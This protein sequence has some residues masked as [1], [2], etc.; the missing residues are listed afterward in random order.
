M[1]TTT[2]AVTGESPR[3][4]VVR[5]RLVMRTLGS[6]ALVMLATPCAAGVAEADTQRTFEGRWVA[7]NQSLTLDLSRCGQALLGS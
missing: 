5:T 2:T 6:V 7:N 3:R 4:A 1:R